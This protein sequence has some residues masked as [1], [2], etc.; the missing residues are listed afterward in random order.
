MLESREETRNRYKHVAI[1]RV[2][3]AY[4][5]W[6]LI[7]FDDQSSINSISTAEDAGKLEHMEMGN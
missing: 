4:S 6:R 3:H 2:G 7:R 1:R 5:S